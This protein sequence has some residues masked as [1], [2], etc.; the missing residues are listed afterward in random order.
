L[1]KNKIGITCEALSERYLGL[2]IVVGR[3]KRGAFKHLTDRSRGKI[4]GWKGQGLSMAGKEILI[5]SVLQAISTYSMGV[6]L[7]NKG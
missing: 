7:Q 4:S 3:S 5:K 6:F 1:L 2:P